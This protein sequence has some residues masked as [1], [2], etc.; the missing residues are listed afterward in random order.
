[1]LSNKTWNGCPPV[2]KH[3][4]ATPLS[5]SKWQLRWKPVCSSTEIE[6]SKW[7]REKPLVS[8][9]PRAIISSR[10]NFGRGQ[11]GKVWVAP[12]GGVWLSAAFPYFGDRKSVASFGLAVALSL[13]ERLERINIPVQIKWP[14]DLIVKGS[15]LAGILPGLVFRGNACRVARVGVGLNVSNK[16]PKEGIS[17]KYLLNDRRC[18]STIW[19]SEV[20]FSLERAMKLL[21]E[22]EVLNKKVE[23]RLWS[24]TFFEV[25]TGK[26]WDIEGVGI[27]GSLKLKKGSQKMILTRWE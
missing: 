10:Q 6:L 3:L 15:K 20:L 19:T 22:E 2:A 24:K 8:H 16:V 14:N 21:E 26:T 23:Q 7:L 12:V 17:L 18:C 4:Q 13:S 25:Q 5:I 11:R 9:S 1:M 27:G